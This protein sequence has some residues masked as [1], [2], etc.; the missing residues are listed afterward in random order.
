MNDDKPDLLE[1]LEMPKFY[2]FLADD[3]RKA[4][5]ALEKECEMLN[6]WQASHGRKFPGKR[7]MPTEE[8]CARIEGRERAIGMLAAVLEK[9]DESVAKMVAELTGRAQ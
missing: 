9:F 5:A 6:E 8:V 1:D 2:G 3:V 7:W 4:Q